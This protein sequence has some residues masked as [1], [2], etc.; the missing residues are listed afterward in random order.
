M[1]AG[2]VRL[3]LSRRSRR[4]LFPYPLKYLRTGWL[5]TRHLPQHDLEFQEDGTH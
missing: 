2:G 5:V 4:G 1:F 3:Q